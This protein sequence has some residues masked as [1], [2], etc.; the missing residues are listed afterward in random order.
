[1]TS[2]NSTNRKRVILRGCKR[3]SG[4]MLREATEYTCMQCGRSAPLPR[5]ER[6]ET[7][8]GAMRLPVNG[9]EEMTRKRTAA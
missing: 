3:C 7:S 6:L 2:T 8:W 9:S 5:G 4:D 1:M